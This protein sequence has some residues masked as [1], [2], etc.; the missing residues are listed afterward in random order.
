VLSWDEKS[1]THRFRSWLPDGRTLDVEAKVGDR[2]WEWGYPDPRAGQIRYTLTLDEKGRWHEV[3]ESSRDG[4]AWRPF[5]E[6]TLEK[7]P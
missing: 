5:L 3:G 6:M 4:Q 2:R 1:G 7:Q